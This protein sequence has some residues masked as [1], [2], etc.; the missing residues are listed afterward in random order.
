MNSLLYHNIRV[1]SLAAPMEGGMGE[2]SAPIG[3][4]KDSTATPTTLYG[5]Q[6]RRL[7]VP[8]SRLV[9]HFPMKI[10]SILM[11]THDN[12]YEVR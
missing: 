12:S 10:L 7:G 2:R 5:R 1:N 9:S 4:L 3:D 11:N 8:L 6:G